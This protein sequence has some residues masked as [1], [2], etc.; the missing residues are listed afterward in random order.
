[1]SATIMSREIVTY[2]NCM[3]EVQRISLVQSVLA[4]SVTTGQDAFDTELIFVQFRKV[5]EQIAFASL[6]ANKVKYSAAYA[7]FATHWNAQ[8][9]LRD[10]KK[11]NPDFYPLPLDL[12]SIGDKGTNRVIHF[13]PVFDG[14]MTQDDFVCLYDKCGQIL[15]ARNPFN[16][17]DPVIQIGYSVAQWVTRIRRLLATHLVHL[18][19]SDVW[20]V[21]IPND[22]LVRASLA[23]PTEGIAACDL[24]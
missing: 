11:I 15:H 21:T 1:M 13:E 12:V 9:M 2:C 18:V 23:R 6:A 7:T 20:V 17:Q 16:P 4:R 3:E 19:D 14:F 22:G 24:P 10:L 8:R 5:L